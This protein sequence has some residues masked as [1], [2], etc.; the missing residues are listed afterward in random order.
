VNCG[1][2]QEW[3]GFVFTE[4]GP[5]PRRIYADYLAD[6]WPLDVAVNTAAVTRLDDLAVTPRHLRSL[7]GLDERPESIRSGTTHR[8]P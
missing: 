2:P 3:N 6:R 8:Y 5:A 7:L 1:W 4:S